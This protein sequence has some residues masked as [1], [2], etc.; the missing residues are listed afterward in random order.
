ME[1]KKK[2][3][4]TKVG[5][6]INK[7]A[8]DVIDTVGNI[9]P[10]VNVLKALLPESALTPGE[11]VEFNAA[12]KEYELKELQ[13]YLKDIQGAREM[14][15][16]IQ[17]AQAGS[18]LSKVAAYILDFVIAGATIVVGLLLF[19]KAIPDENKEIAYMLFGSLL[20]LTGTVINFHRGTSQ[21]SSKKTD[22]MFNSFTNSTGK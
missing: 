13:E 17:E 20:T 14:N 12:L 2:F 1:D 8:P 9:F 18:K 10:A 19:F 21:G 11:A 5:Q 4:D 3:K 15:V 7:V 16:R 22:M 6:F